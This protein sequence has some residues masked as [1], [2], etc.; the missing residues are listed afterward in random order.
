MSSENH[1]SALWRGDFGRAYTDRNPTTVEEMEA[2]TLR[3]YGRG[4]GAINA[5]LLADVDRRGA[6]LEVGCNV[7]LQLAGLRRQGFQRLV[8]M[9][10]QSYPLEIA[11]RRLPD[12][13]VVQGSALALPFASGSFDMVFTSGVLIHVAPEPRR[14]VM[15]EIHRCSREWIWGLEYFSEEPRALAYRGEDE[16]LW[17]CDFVEAYREACPGLEVH[18]RVKLPYLG[19]DLVDEAFLLRKA[20]GA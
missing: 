4:R 5:E 1:Q 20:A 9:D 13:S 10:I 3:R 11:R 2:L 8:G 7:G 18:L 15:A 16:A 17:K 12:L 14:Q 19:E 6:V